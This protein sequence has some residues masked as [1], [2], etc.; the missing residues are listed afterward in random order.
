GAFPIATRSLSRWMLP[1][2][3]GFAQGITHAGARL[4]GAI[5]PVFVV[6]LILHFGWRAPFFI[7]ALIGLIW[8][9]IWFFYYRDHPSE[10]SGTNQAERDLIAAALGAAPTTARP[11]AVP[12]RQLLG[13]LDIWTLSA[14]Y[15][16]YAYSIG[17]F[18]T[19]FP[20]Y[21]ND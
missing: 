10:H 19:W 17:I 6:F 11:G 9:A 13:K 2:E 21:L 20:K 18:L 15:F 7:F 1:A 16:C 4:G 8:A 12:W 3:R 5:T 14:M